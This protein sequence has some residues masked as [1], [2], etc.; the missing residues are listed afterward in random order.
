[1]PLPGSHREPQ[2]LQEIKE[3]V[4]EKPVIDEVKEPVHTDSDDNDLSE[5]IAQAES[6]GIT[7]K[8]HWGKSQL[9]MAIR[10]RVAANK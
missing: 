4:H 10:L 5:L 1:M 3:P 7:V 8:H 2:F 6:M 9:E